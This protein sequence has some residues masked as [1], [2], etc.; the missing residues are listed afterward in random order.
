MSSAEGRV[1][2][3]RAAACAGARGDALDAADGARRGPTAA[4]R[5]RSWPRR[6]FAIVQPPLSGPTRFSFGTRGALEERLA[7]RGRAAGGQERLHRDALRLHV[8]EEEADAALLLGG[9]VGAHEH[10]DPVGVLRVR[11]PRLLPRRRRSG[12]RRRPLPASSATRG[13]CRR[14]ARS[15]PGTTRPRPPGSPAGSAL[16]RVRAEL[17][18]AAGRP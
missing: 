18:D 16:L 9:R 12:R 17:D 11:R 7:E 3:Q 5:V 10:E 15:S 14:W 6:A 13:R 8:A 2:E 1:V 4:M